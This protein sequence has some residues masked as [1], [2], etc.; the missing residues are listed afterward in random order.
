MPP[1][2]EDLVATTP[3]RVQKTYEILHKNLETLRKRLNRPLTLSEKIVYG[4]LKDPGTQSLEVG[5][6]L[7]LLPDRVCMQDATAQMA[8]LQFMQSGRKRVAVPSTLH[9]DHLIQ[10]HVGASQDLKTAIDANREVY[11]F[12]KSSAAKYGMGFWGPGSGIIH[13]V[14]LEQYAYPGGFVI[15]T[16]SHTPNGGGLSM[17]A[18]GVGGADAAE[19]M[20]GSYFEVA[21]PRLIGVRLKGNLNGWAAPKDIILKV[22]ELLTTKGGTNC[23]LEYFGE[24]AA[25]ISA[26]GKATITNMG[27]ELGATTSLFPYDDHSEKY[28][29]VTNRSQI[30]AL[31]TRVQKELLSADP[32]VE[33]NPQSYFSKV[34]EIDLSK[35]EPYVVGPHSPDVAHPISQ[36]AQDVK[37]NQYPERLHACLIGS[38]TNSSYEDLSRVVD[39]AKQAQSLGLKVKTKLMISPGSEMIYETIKRDGFVDVLESVGAVVL[40]NACGPCI[41]QW[42]R[43]DIQKG[44]AN[45]ILTSFNR[46]FPRRN[47]GNPETMAFI[48]SPE[49]VMAMSFSGSL[50]FNP[51]KDSL[52]NVK[53]QDVKFSVPKVAA[54]IPP[55][56]FS[57]K[58]INYF[59]PLPEEAPIE[60]VVHPKSERLQLLKPFEK[61]DG[62]DFM[63]LP[64][65]LKAKG[66]CTTDHISPA[67][68]WLRYRGHLDKISDNMFMGAVNSFSDQPGTGY[69]IN[70]TEKNQ[71]LSGIAREYHSH[72]IGWVVIGDENYGEG[73]SREHAAM[74]PRYL[75]CKVVV[76]RSFARIHETNL[77]KQGI[78]PLTF[79]NKEDYDKIRV[80]DFISL[81]N[82]K[83]LAPGSILQCEIFHSDDKTR[84]QIQLRHSLTLEHIEWFK[85]GSAMNTFSNV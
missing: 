81:L 30:A 17:I 19:V 23:I 27:A 43:D 48:G 37:D 40:A 33:K 67:G 21:N 74:S 10:A 84:E 64:V 7:Q 16:D 1:N 77:K 80:R 71:P 6:T 4:H 49:L 82:L 3:E 52:K 83:R 73:S 57:Q 75:G 5:T 38:C 25:S 39:I 18:I 20:A 11:D 50:L 31:A 2:T 55:K 12:L 8:I 34:I 9:C 42:K 72:G 56:G 85:A 51:L 68:P 47:D 41:G 32:E 78:L 54:E 58:A 69:N 62:K 14:F 28:L 46:N 66:K 79:V 36:L 60:I 45:S 76:A 63:E 24:G 65:L 35:L 29:K 53:G 44:Q 15:G 61:W 13:Q 59:L 26:T 70:N 22:C